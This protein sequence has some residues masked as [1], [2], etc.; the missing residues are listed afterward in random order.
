M[1]KIEAAVN[2]VPPVQGT[3][4]ELAKIDPALAKNPLIFP[5]LSKLH[6]FDPK[7]ADNKGYKQQFQTAIGS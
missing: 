5:D 3:K 4:E 7:A 2:Y 6:A 1:A